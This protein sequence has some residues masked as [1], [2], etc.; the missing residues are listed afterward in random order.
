MEIYARIC[1]KTK[2]AY[3]KSELF[4]TDT[5]ISSDFITHILSNSFVDGTPESKLGYKDILEFILIASDGHDVQVFDIEPEDVWPTGFVF[6]S[7]YHLEF[8]K[9]GVKK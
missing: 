7:A 8:H 2:N 3:Y 5:V 1:F 4:S 9:E 6:D